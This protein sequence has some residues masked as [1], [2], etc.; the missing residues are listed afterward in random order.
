MMM[1]SKRARPFSLAGML[2]VTILTSAFPLVAQPQALDSTLLAALRRGA[3]SARLMRE[4]STVPLVGT[5]TL[6]LVEARINGRGP[7][8]LLLDLGS[9]VTLLRRSVVDSSGTTVL[10]DRERGDIIR[11]DS[12]VIGA[13]L[14]TAVTGAAYD[15]LDVD[16]VIGFNLLRIFPFTIDYPRARFVFHGDSLPEPDG[17]R[18]LAYEVHGRMP[19][20][21]AYA[22]TDTLLLNFDTGA[23]EWM[24]VPLAWKD[25]LKSLSPAVAGPVVTNNQTGDVR[26]LTARLAAP[27]R[28][29]GFTI[30]NIPVYLNADV[31][32]AW[33][34]SGLLQHFTLTFDPQRNRMRLHVPSGES[35]LQAPDSIP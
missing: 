3:P 29:G 12:L 24:T 22:G 32:D 5:A 25:S 4:R 26:V 7:Y 35:T 28:I 10:I 23:A 20:V 27:L 11:I 15:D 8:R 2:A 17:A 19:Y 34:G 30:A 9:N 1:I 21:R 18:V 33:I 13:A 14:F 6:P 16:G 31:E